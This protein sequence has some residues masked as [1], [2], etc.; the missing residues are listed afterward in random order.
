MGMDEMMCGE[1]TPS[2]EGIYK[3]ESLVGWWEHGGDFVWHT[4]WN[5][6]SNSYLFIFLTKKSIKNLISFEK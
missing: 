2:L 5:Q 6:N 3:G 4:D 1:H